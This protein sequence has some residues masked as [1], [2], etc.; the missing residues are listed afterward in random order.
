MGIPDPVINL[1][2]RK[3]FVSLALKS[4]RI[5]TVKKSYATLRMQASGE[6]KQTFFLDSFAYRQWEVNNE[7][8]G[9]FIE[10]HN[11]SFSRTTK[12]S[13]H[14]TYWPAMIKTNS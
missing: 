2:V 12:N 11:L 1:T 13:N 8:A 9:P 7:G 14:L 5:T 10:Y 3:S 4:L 6:S